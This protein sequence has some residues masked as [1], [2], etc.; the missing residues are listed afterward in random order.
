MLLLSL[1]LSSQIFYPDGGHTL[2][3]SSGCVVLPRQPECTGTPWVRP[4][5]PLR[6][7]VAVSRPHY[8]H[9]LSLLSTCHRALEDMDDSCVHS[10]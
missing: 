3:S 2:V 10:S 1:S 8:C 9:S 5:A 4:V 7:W 6:A